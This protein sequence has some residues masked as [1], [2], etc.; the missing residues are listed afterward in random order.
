MRVGETAKKDGLRYVHVTQVMDDG[1]FGP[2]LSGWTRRSNLDLSGATSDLAPEQPET[3]T[4]NATDPGDVPGLSATPAIDDPAFQQILDL[5][6]EM[7][8]SPVAIEKTHKEETGGAR[9]ERVRQI[10]EV[11]ARIAELTPDALNVTGPVLRNAVAYL[12]RRLAPLAPYYNQIANTNM[13]TK[14]D[15]KGWERTCNVTVPAMIIEGLGKSRAD[16]DG[17][18]GDMALLQQIFDA[19]E[20]K[21]L[22]RAQYEAAAD[23]EALRLPD[24][25][26]L[27]GIA[28]KMPK[29][30]AGLDADAFDRAVSK[31]RDKAAASTTA[32]ATITDLLS[33]FGGQPKDHWLLTSK[34]E[35]I[36]TARRD[37]TRILLGAGGKDRDE[38]KAKYDAME[39]E[40]D[41]LLPVS[42][43]RAAVLKQV[44][45]LLD[46]GAQIL[47]GMENHFVRLDAL[48][49]TTLQID[50]PGYGTLKNARLTWKQARDFG[51][52]KTFW[53][54]TA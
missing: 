41:K 35:T 49:E 2:P 36:G 32:H 27:A 11:R 10:A 8:S 15:K 22:A 26:S 37:Y 47:V 17:R 53:S 29:D 18:W 30:A 1:A 20:G 39:E 54:V 16:Y 12:Y 46:A 50:D 6:A 45:P 38:K 44:N 34:L 21:Y 13:L 23:F 3:T 40:A 31:A 7:E 19:L 28:R 9:Q 5:L 24:F 42:Q 14:G 52:F 4:P 43:Y 33:A 25:M 51:M 48:D